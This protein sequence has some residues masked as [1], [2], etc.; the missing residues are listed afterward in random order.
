MHMHHMMQTQQQQ[1]GGDIG[2]VSSMA[3]LLKIERVAS[4]LANERTWLAWVRT[5]AAG[6]RRGVGGGCVDGCRVGALGGDAMRPERGYIL[7]ILEFC[8]EDT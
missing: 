5:T 3:Y 6:K 8:E 7:P 2:G 1:H 4:H